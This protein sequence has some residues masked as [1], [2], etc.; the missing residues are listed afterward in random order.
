MGEQ[1]KD[2]AA[3]GAVAF[4]R[5]TE[6]YVCREHPEIGR[7][8][9]VC[10]F[11]PT[12]VDNGGL[13]VEVDDSLDGTDVAAL[14]ARV[15]EAIP[16]FEAMPQAPWKKAL[17]LVFAGVPG[18]RAAVVDEV[19]AALKPE[20]V[21]RGLMLGQ[22]HPRST[23]A[24][25]RNPAFHANRAPFAAIAVRHMSYHDIVFLDRSAEMFR[26]YQARY[27]EGPAGAGD[28]DP[29]LVARYEAA[30]ARFGGVAVDAG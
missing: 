17:A 30:L 24:G 4:W 2:R 16:V 9:P 29:F 5:W 25:A 22:F 14:E 7:E 21:R 28:A 20:C 13:R 18:D 6:D 26:E 3:E 15:R 19:Q 10:P 1:S 8:G 12:V 23:E 27:P 11:L